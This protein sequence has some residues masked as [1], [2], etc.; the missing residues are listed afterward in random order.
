MARSR[1]MV[2]EDARGWRYYWREGDPFAYMLRASLSGDLARV[3]SQLDEHGI[4][5]PGSV[6]A[7]WTPDLFD[8]ARVRLLAIYEKERLRQMG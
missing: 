6:G 7:R 3:C 5:P 4:A 2:Y 1:V 8:V